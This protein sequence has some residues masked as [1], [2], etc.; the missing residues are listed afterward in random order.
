MDPE[1]GPS[2]SDFAAAAWGFLL[3]FCHLFFY[4]F[5]LFVGLKEDFVK[6]RFGY[7]AL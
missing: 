7:D 6:L 1:F 2:R 4:F 3:L 5:P